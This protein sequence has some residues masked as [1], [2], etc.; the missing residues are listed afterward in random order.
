MALDYQ[1]APLAKF[2]RDSSDLLAVTIPKIQA[3][4][5]LLVIAPVVSVC[6]RR[7]AGIRSAIDNTPKNTAI[8]PVSFSRHISNTLPNGGLTERVRRFARTM[9]RRLRWPQP[10]DTELKVLSVVSLGENWA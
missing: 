9:R 6:A 8:T 5:T 2:Q 3:A 4:N 1:A 7:T 10:L